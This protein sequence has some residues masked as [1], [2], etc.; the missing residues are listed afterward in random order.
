MNNKKL[1]ALLLALAATASNAGTMGPAVTPERLLLIE[2]GVSY[3]HAFYDSFSLFPESRSPFNPSG[4]GINPRDFYPNDFWGGYIGASLYTPSNW[5]LNA[6][7]DMYSNERKYNAVAETIIELAPV[8]LSFTVDKV[9]GNFSDLS[10]GLGAG[11]VV[12][13]LNDGELFVPVDVH[14]PPSE[15][16][17]GRTIIDPLVEAFVMYRFVNNFGIKLNAAYQIPFNTKFGNG[18]VN[19]NLGCNYAFPI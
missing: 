18:D 19:V 13:S 14:N 8:K 15:S 16:F 4:F 9:W 2:G 11:A 7:Y 6:R 1:S 10:F 5:L 12:E 3:T 17:Q